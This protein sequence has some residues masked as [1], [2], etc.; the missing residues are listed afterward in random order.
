M[1]I[2]EVK[3]FTEYDTRNK[4]TIGV[5]IKSD[6][7]V[8]VVSAS[9][10]SGKSTG[11]YEANPYRKS[12]EDDI[13]TVNAFS[14]KL[15]EINFDDF[16]DLILVEKL[17]REKA[18]ANSLFA[19]ESAILKAT[20]KS[21]QM[22]VYELLNSN[23]KKM[24]CLVGNCIGGGVHDKINGPDF[25]E[26]LFIPNADTEQS[27]LI[28]KRAWQEAGEMLERE[29]ARFGYRKS[30][31][32][33]WQTTLSNRRVLEVMKKVSDKIL[34]ETGIKMRIGIDVAASSL[35]GG[36]FK[37]GYRY[38]NPKAKLMRKE[39][40]DYIVS[41]VKSYGVFYLEDP[42]QEEDF[43]GF[44]SL[45]RR[46]K[47]FIV[48]DDLTVTNLNRLRKAVKNKSINSVIIKPNQ[49]GSLVNVKQVIDYAKSVGMKI[50]FSHRSGET[51]DDIIADL[52]VAWEAD[53]IKTGITGEGRE[54]KLVR[55]RQ[56]WG[57]VGVGG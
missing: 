19:L 9:A 54:E 5:A 37:K 13:K 1:R 15:K 35:Y 30:D 12:L 22:S 48:G 27:I 18:G 8:G 24:P 47:S 25:Q 40:I 52:A 57:K 49:N 11:K 31:E 32:N 14:D 17:L 36:F 6:T 55:L 4:E 34:T 51:R 33:A 50:V 53:F 2:R 42:L 43:L 7:F 26:F 28:N 44:A 38:S 46:L 23:A 10:P 41:L 45:G 39:H 16:S 56:I 21:R 3:A 29:D 20:A